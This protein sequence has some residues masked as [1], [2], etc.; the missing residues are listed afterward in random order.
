MMKMHLKG[1]V[2][3][4]IEAYVRIQTET[5]NVVSSV[6]TIG[7]LHLY[8]LF[9]PVWRTSIRISANLSSQKTFFSR[10]FLCVDSNAAQPPSFPRQIHFCW[11]D[12]LILILYVI[13]YT[14]THTDISHVLVFPC[15]VSTLEFNSEDSSFSH[16]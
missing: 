1:C 5:D 14:R 7:K 8:K 15:L 11:N 4:N 9:H 13:A 16:D 3:F 12:S 10:S 2:V 6:K